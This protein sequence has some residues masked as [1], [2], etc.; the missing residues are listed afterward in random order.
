VQ[1]LRPE[2]RCEGRKP[3]GSRPAEAVVV[4]RIRQLRRKPNGKPRLSVAA[5]AKILKRRQ[6]AHAP[7][8]AV[9]ARHRLRHSPAS[10]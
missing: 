3:F 10:L 5:I 9:A 4:E 6:S 2:P 7:G 1:R 8:R